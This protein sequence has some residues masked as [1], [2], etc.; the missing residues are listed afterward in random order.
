MEGHRLGFPDRLQFLPTPLPDRLR[1]FVPCPENKNVKLAQN[2]DKYILRG[3]AVSVIR[4]S[5]SLTYL[6]YASAAESKLHNRLLLADF[7]VLCSVGLAPSALCAHF[8]AAA[9]AAK[10]NLPYSKPKSCG[11]R[12]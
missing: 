10:A 6:T 9:T 2:I 12:E 11:L 5:N 1:R 4:N 3:N 7:Q 8:F